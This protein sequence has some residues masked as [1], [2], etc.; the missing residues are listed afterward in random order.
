MAAV[1][2]AGSVASG[3]FAPASSDLDV[4]AL[5]DRPVT[6]A[7]RKALRTGHRRLAK[8][9]PVARRL[10]CV[11]VPLDAVADANRTHLTWAH[12]EFFQ[13]PLN[14][15]A[16]VELLHGAVVLHG[17]GPGGVVPPVPLAELQ[18]YV[19]RDLEEY[20]LPHTRRRRIWLADIWVDLGLLTLVRGAGTLVENGRLIT[21]RE[22]I[23]RLPGFDV[24]AWVVEDI[25]HRRATGRT[26]L[27]ALARVRRAVVARRLVATGVV[28]VLAMRSGADGA[29]S[30]DG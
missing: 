30:G 18:E 11:Y 6:A 23:A 4:V 19:R 14:V 16:R 27:S 25:A 17:R 28:R 20:W 22:A 5:L 24:P 9:H 15:V 13:R 3:D 10:H 12:G 26:S 29:V 2:V 8:F 1:W 21:K 7:E